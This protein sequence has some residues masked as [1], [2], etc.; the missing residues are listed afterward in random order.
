M[1]SSQIDQNRLRNGSSDVVLT[2]LVWRYGLALLAF[3]LLMLIILTFRH[4]SI[5][6]SLSLLIVAALIAVAWYGGTGPG[7]MVAILFEIAT[8][9]LSNPRQVSWPMFFFAEFNRTAMLVILILLVSS[10]KKAENRLREQHER[11]RASEQRF[12]KAFNASPVPMSIVTDQEGRYLEV[13]E[14]FLRN[15]GY[16][17]AEI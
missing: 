14:S 2:P 13:N 10:R 1:T 17:R 15:S 16:T 6:I 5:Q 9:A 8:V 12:A 3:V 11:L 4:Y 7:L